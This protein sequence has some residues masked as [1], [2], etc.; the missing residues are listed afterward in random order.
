MVHYGTAQFNVAITPAIISLPKHVWCGSQWHERLANTA[1]KE[2]IWGGCKKCVFL[3]VRV[4]TCVFVHVCLY[5]YVCMFVCLCVYF[6]VFLFLLVCLLACLFVCLSVCLFAFVSLFVL[7]SSNLCGVCAL[8]KREAAN[9]DFDLESLS[10]YPLIQPSVYS[11]PLFV[12][13]L[14]QVKPCNHPCSS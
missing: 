4:C 6:C 12:E 2:K 8:W 9:L 7:M 11:L 5:V 14:K 10:E 3:C 1:L 13:N